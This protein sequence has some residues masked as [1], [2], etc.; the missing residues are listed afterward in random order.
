MSKARGSESG[1]PEKIIIE[2]ENK[3]AKRVSI[4]TFGHV[5]GSSDAIQDIE[6]TKLANIRGP[7]SKIN[8]C[9]DANYF[10]VLQLANFTGS[11]RCSSKH[12]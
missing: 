10:D 2:G 5:W 6:T 3:W 11:K 7:C 9:A 8:L 4:S 1:P 12:F